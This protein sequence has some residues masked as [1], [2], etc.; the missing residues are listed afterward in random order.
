MLLLNILYSRVFLLLPSL[1]PTSFRIHVHLLFPHLF[2]HGCTSYGILVGFV[3]GLFRLCL[4]L[5]KF[6]GK[7]YRGKIEE[8]KK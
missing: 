6:E 1:N 5:R 8:K 7:G 3:S 2:F 4:V